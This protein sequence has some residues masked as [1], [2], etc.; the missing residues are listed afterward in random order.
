[1][2]DIIVP[3]YRGLE[4]TRACLE[5]VFRSTNIEPY[6]LIVINDCSPDRELVEWLREEAQVRPML[7]LE[8]PQNL[9][10]VATVNRG[11]SQSDRHDVLL[12]NSDTEVSADWID[13]LHRAAY[14]APDIAT[15][16]P[17]SN[18]ATICSYPAFC[19][20]NDLPKG[21]DLA[22][23]DCLFAQTNSR[24]T[25]E[26]PTAVG[27][28]MFIRRE[29]LSRIGKFDVE[30]FGRGYGE[31]N[32]FCCRAV[33]AGYRNVLAADV[34][35]WHK[36]NVSFGDAHN[37][38][39]QQALQKLLDRHPDYTA[40]VEAHVRADPAREARLAVDIR[41]WQESGLPRILL[42][43]HDRGGGTEQHCR[44][45]ANLVEGEAHVFKL[46][47]M[48]GGR[49]CL[50]AMDRGEAAKFYFCLPQD[51]HRLVF[52]LECIGVGRVHFHHLLGLDD[53]IRK[54]PSDL[55]VTY[56][57]TT[58][59]Y[60]FLCPHI[61][62]TGTDDRYC[63]EEGRE[64]CARCL[65][66]RPVGGY[67][68]DAWRTRFS[69]W[70]Q[71]ASR[72]IAPSAD[73]A[74]RFAKGFGLTNLLVAEH[75]DALEACAVTVASPHAT[76][77][78]LRVAVLGALSPIKG[79]DLLEGAALDAQRR[80]LPIRFK[81]FG[82]AYRSLRQNDHLAVHGPYA[83]EELDAL[84][85]QWCPD[86]VWFPAQGP[87]TYSYTLSACFKVG[88]PVLASNLGAL[89]ERIQGRPHSWGHD[90]R[91]DPAACNQ[92]LLK[93]AA[94][95]LSQ[96]LTYTRAAS[97]ASFYLQ[98]YL[99][100]AGIPASTR[101]VPEHDW[102]AATRLPEEAVSVWRVRVLGWLLRMR[103]YPAL[104]WL[105]PRI[106]MTLQRRIKNRLLGQA[107]ERFT[108]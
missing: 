101:N 14:S 28:C 57:V 82:Y 51:Y 23:L 29:A 54:L 83:A 79:A 94:E 24:L 87:E 6:R 68:I 96:P 37:E 39:K 36:G 9:G 18:N 80:R 99:A 45:L 11:M 105:A 41:R 103:G 107:N 30:R 35:V 75:P 17:F 71:G 88:L 74:R 108:K 15:V 73:T 72:V 100:P 81:L 65:K 33:A 86:I 5:S 25:I 46:A 52:L 19:E 55:G 8:N 27:F 56:D 43:T 89:H 10:F 1:M 34:F 26:I 42:V 12:L 93:I 77:R 48:A 22:S 78:D 31:E 20:D 49:V 50:N 90:W 95:A 70:L 32:D 62:L 91:D 63:G 13:R 53:C 85:R 97:S 7:L 92:R 98:D 67:S 40:G 59:D 58:H 47:P 66:E 61:S 2:I 69:A 3:V 44:E 76:G 64:Q 21:H 104:R 106:P 38:L 102:L 84:L 60:Y 16:T 4:E